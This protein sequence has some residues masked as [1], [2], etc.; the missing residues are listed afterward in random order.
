MISAGVYGY[1]KEQ[2]FRVASDTILDFLATHEQ[3]D[4][5]TV[6]IVILTA[7]AF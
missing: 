1:P 4:D 7:T 3:A 5:M 2:A 6:Y